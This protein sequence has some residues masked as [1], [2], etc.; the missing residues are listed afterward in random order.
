MTCSH[1]RSM[2]NKPILWAISLSRVVLPHSN[3]YLKT[4]SVYDNLPTGDWPQN[5]ELVLRLPSNIAQKVPQHIIALTFY[6]KLFGLTAAKRLKRRRAQR[7]KV[8]GFVNLWKSPGFPPRA[9]VGQA[10]RPSPFWGLQ[11]KSNQY[12]IWR[13]QGWSIATPIW[14]GQAHSINRWVY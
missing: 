10:D 13:D 8:S 6:W 5:M 1:K 14:K 3:R 12:S 4:F 9:A 7:A 11:D 2:I